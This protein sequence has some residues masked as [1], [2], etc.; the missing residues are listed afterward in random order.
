MAWTGRAS[1]N[2]AP[3]QGPA[4]VRGDAARVS[5]GTGGLQTVCLEFSRILLCGMKC[6]GKDSCSYDKKEGW[7]FWG[8]LF[9]V[10]LLG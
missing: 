2:T 6:F 8:I 3:A 10:D 4:E 7:I 5:G 1:E 9:Q